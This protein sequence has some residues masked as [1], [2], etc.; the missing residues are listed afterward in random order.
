M[1]RKY[2][3]RI[4]FSTTSLGQRMY[5][6][7]LDRINHFCAGLLSSTHRRPQTYCMDLRKRQIVAE[8]Q[9][10]CVCP[11]IMACFPLFLEVAWGLSQRTPVGWIS[12]LPAGHSKRC[13]RFF[14][15]ILRAGGVRG[16]RR[17]IPYHHTWKHSLMYKPTE[18]CALR[19]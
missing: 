7:R 8:N 15:S 3:F 9:E 18:D 16:G 5:C 11:W 17:R 1:T 6:W 19:V 4:F 13:V 14:P 10:Y 2:D 12:S